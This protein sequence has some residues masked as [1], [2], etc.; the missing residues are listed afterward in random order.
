LKVVLPWQWNGEEPQPEPAGG[1][2]TAW[3]Q[4]KGRRRGRWAGSGRFAGRGS[5]MRSGG[6]DAV[7]GGWRGAC[8]A[9][10]ARGGGGPACAHMH[11]VYIYTICIYICIYIY[12]LYI[13][14]CIY[15][16]IYI[17]IYMHVYTVHKYMYM[18]INVYVYTVYIHTVP[19]RLPR[20]RRHAECGRAVQA[21]GHVRLE[22]AGRQPRPPACSFR[23]SF[24]S[25]PPLQSSGW[26]RERL[27]PATRC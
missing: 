24:A 12:T 23:S 5:S 17:H 22:R 26:G 19:A 9:A 1:E 16:H 27:R 8:R 2:A 4:G 3:Q 25:P 7:G 20:R 15:I 14:I 6:L 18:Y 21:E 13:S 11:P 10:G